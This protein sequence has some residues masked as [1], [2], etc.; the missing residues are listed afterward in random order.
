MFVI[1]SLIMMC[2]TS[3]R[4]FFS[5]GVNSPAGVSAISPL[6]ENVKVPVASSKFHVI[7]SP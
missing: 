6:P 2:F 4:K 5:H 1:P 7:F 3:V